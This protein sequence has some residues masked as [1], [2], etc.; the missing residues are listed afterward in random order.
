MGGAIAVP[1]NVTPLAEFNHWACAYSAAQVY[2][3]TSPSPASTLPCGE[4]RNSWPKDKKLSEEERL[5]LTVFTL[6]ITTRHL[7]RWSDV[8]EIVA[9]LAEKGSP[10]AA[11]MKVFAESTFGRI[12]GVYESELD[13]ALHDPVCVWYVMTQGKGWE[14]KK[15]VDVRVE[16]EG[17]WTRGMCIVDKRGKRVVDETEAEML[18]HDKGGWLHKG[19]GNRVNLAYKGTDEE[20]FGRG[21][22]ERIFRC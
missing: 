7:L 10:L 22:L 21:I 14:I 3:Y 12:E 8:Q 1:G 4:I 17:Q 20:A 11:W 16:A 2:A 19:L 18:E 13:L 9:P 15:H 5:N 6:D